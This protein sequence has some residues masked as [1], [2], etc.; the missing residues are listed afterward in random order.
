M[1]EAMLW[2]PLQDQ[3][4]LCSLCSHRCRIP[5]QQYGFCSVRKNVGGKLYT[6]AY[7]KTV[8]E[9]VDPVEKKPLFHFLPAST[10]FSVATIGCNFRCGFCQNWNISQA[11]KGDIEGKWG[12]PADPQEIVDRAL[13]AGCK[14]ISFTYTE[15]TIFFEYTFDIARLA[16]ENGLK[17]I[18]VSN[19]YMTDEALDVISPYLDA[20]NIDL[21]S[22]RDDYYRKLCK[23]RL[24]PVLDSLQK[25]VQLGI[26]LEITTLVV[27]G[28]N[29]SVEELR[30]I[31]SFIADNLDS[32]VPWH[33]SRFFPQY[34]LTS[35]PP[36][37][38]STIEKA[39]RIGAESGLRFIYAGNVGGDTDTLCPVCG[40]TLVHRSGYRTDRL[41]IE[42]GRC[43]SC[44][45]EIRGVWE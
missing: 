37:P 45:T 26:W 20:C 2:N 33:V 15:P 35:L 21:K 4:V 6:Y 1:K 27:T 19:G 34:E 17:T 41:W 24:E 40:E 22:F 31:A 14:S 25:I 12:R 5:S 29:D 3:T 30:N 9:Q 43:R 23:A 44:R 28:E 32:S 8:S 36:T 38:V 18:F 39:V 7:G 10:T 11:E 13:Q 16:K 42:S